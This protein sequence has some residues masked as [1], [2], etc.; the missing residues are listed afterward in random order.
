MG[1]RPTQRD[2][3]A[4][5]L[6]TEIAQATNRVNAIN[7]KVQTA[8]VIAIPVVA[9]GI[10]TTVKQP[11]SIYSNLFSFQQTPIFFFSFGYF[12][13]K[14]A[15]DKPKVQT[16]TAVP[17]LH[18]IPKAET[19]IN[20][21]AEPSVLNFKDEPGV[22]NLK[23]EPGILNIKAEQMGSINVAGNRVVFIKSPSLTVKFS[24][25]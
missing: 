3:V 13:K 19:S 23:T 10:R 11:V 16:A 14:T 25:F 7:S 21:K 12:I 18:Q 2:V 17:V 20:F 4:A 8:Q 9:S 22:D 5:R 24:N 15:V 1:G 6:Q